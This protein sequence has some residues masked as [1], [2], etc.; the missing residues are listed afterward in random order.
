MRA[1]EV[2][3]GF[4]YF[5]TI[6]GESRT[7]KDFEDC[8]PAPIYLWSVLHYYNVCALGYTCNQLKC[9]LNPSK[10]TVGK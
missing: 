3:K 1:R 2:D 9:R 6:G 8:C 5:G 10:Y 7:P 4:A